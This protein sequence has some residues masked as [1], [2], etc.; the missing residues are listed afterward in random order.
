MA[1]VCLAKDLKDLKERLGNILV[2]YNKENEPIYAKQLNA[3][4]AMAVLLKTH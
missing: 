3:E 2:G 1:I 4:G